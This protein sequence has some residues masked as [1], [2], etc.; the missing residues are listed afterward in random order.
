M[1]ALGVRERLE[2]VRRNT[3]EIISEEELVRILQEK[4]KPSVY[5]GTAPTGKPHIGY[6]FPALKIADFLKAGFKVKILLADL[7]A[8]MDNVPWSVL[9]KRYK[10]YS[11]I[12]PVMIK[13][14]GVNPKD[15]EFVKGSNFQLKPE[16]MYDVLQMSSMISVHDAHKAASEV[17]KLGNNPRLSGLI[18]PIMQALDEQ[19]LEV[20]AQLGGSDQRKIMVLARENLPRIGYEKRIEIMNPLIPGLT[21]QKMSS[22]EPK[23][24]IDL[25]DSLQEV[26][27]KINSAEC[28]AGEVNNGIISFIKYVLMVIKSDNGEKFTIKRAEKYGGNVSYSNYED[29]ED[30][31]K[32][33]KIH[34]LDLKNALAEEISKLLEE[35]QKNKELFELAKEAYPEKE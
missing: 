12:I 31:F 32:T 11:K 18:Y 24:K 6:F 20:D 15:L 1:R 29:L 33:K 13:A 7:H 14:I 9:E 16:Y 26:K 2:L 34:P 8:A 21:G 23:S 10:Y 25:L 4:K 19:Y 30:D 5:W 3:A 17:V 35:I 28:I 22:S 27:Q